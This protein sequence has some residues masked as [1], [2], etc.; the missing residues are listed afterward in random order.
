MCLI[1]TTPHPNF[2]PCF[3]IFQPLQHQLTL[4]G[5]AAVPCTWQ[6]WPLGDQGGTRWLQECGSRSD[7]GEH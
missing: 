4:M 7:D 6:A 2:Y 5:R 3:I 1:P